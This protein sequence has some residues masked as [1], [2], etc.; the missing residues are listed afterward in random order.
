MAFDAVIFDLDGTLLNTLDDLYNAVNHAVTSFGFPAQTKD[1]VRLHTG[2]GIK[3]L[4]KKSLPTDVSDSIFKEVFT[5][6]KAYY[7]D[8]AADTTSPYPGIPQMLTDLM[9][10]HIPLSVVSNKADF[11]VQTL[12]RD[13]F[14]GTFHVIAG[15]RESEGIPKKP[16][17]Q[18]IDYVRAQL[19]LPEQARVAYVGDSEVDIQTAANA[20]CEAVICMWGFRGREELIAQGAQVLID[21]PAELATYLKTH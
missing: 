15:E 10:A 14:P 7:R 3:N 4:I 20:E 12:I 5:E 16:A 8:H 2:N 21:T 11:A 13:Y 19:D 6:F 1:E 18:I 9:L 17:R